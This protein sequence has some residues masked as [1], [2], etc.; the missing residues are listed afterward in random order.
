MNSKSYVLD[1][2]GGFLIKNNCNTRKNGVAYIDQNGLIGGNWRRASDF[3]FTK[4]GGFID[5]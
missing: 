5:F 3:K 1:F 4:K 2:A